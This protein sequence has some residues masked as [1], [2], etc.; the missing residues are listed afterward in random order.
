[1]ELVR[2]SKS[3]AGELFDLSAAAIK[4]LEACGLLFGGL[5]DEVRAITMLP[6]SADGRVIVLAALKMLSRF[7]SVRADLEFRLRELKRIRR[8]VEGLSNGR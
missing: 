3:P 7:D 6:L 5:V 1:M 2:P 8:E 4:P